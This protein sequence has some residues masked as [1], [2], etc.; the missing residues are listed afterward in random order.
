MT[1]S[2]SCGAI[3]LA[4]AVIACHQPQ[5]IP[6]P[7][8]NGATIISDSL[9]SR[10][11]GFYEGQYSKGMLG[12][13]INYLSGNTVSGYDLHKGLRR[14]L[15]GQVEQKGGVLN[16]T[17]KEPGGN[18]YDGIFVLS[19]DTATGKITG[20]WTPTDARKA[21]AGPVSLSKKDI[22][23]PE[24]RL[25]S[26][27]IGSLG[28]LNFFSDGTCALEYYP[29]KDSN[30]QMMTVRGNYIQKE[31]TFRIEWQRNSY[32]PTLN[33]KLV[34]YP[35]PHPESDSIEQRMPLLKGNGVEFNERFQP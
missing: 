11:K 18:P 6:N 19:L 16:M 34:K 29:S 12:L 23:D 33:M 20:K 15:L 22:P 8:A 28:D 5:S 32:L 30:A 35:P 21:S 27:W 26:T 13:M 31:D 7:S 2:S 3:L 25:G 17:L 24:D 10:S 1:R 9:A 4:L 14:N